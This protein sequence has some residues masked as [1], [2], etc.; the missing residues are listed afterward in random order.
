MWLNRT[1]MD[2]E[3]LENDPVF[4]G[5]D[6]NGD[7]EAGYTLT[8]WKHD[9]TLLNIHFSEREMSRLAWITDCL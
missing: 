8:L 2:M 3:T 5:F 7:R 4:K 9:D 6:I 1:S